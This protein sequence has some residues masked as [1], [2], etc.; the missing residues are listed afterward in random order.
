MSPT[1]LRQRRDDMS[2]Y[3]PERV[4]DI[5]A[6]GR[7]ALERAAATQASIDATLAKSDRTR[8]RAIPRLVRAGLLPASRMTSVAEARARQA[9]R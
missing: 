3:G 4:K 1:N 7:A 2:T 5:L 8:M 6:S 9:K